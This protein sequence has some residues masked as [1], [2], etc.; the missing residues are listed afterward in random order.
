[1]QTTRRNRRGFTLVEFLVVAGIALTAFSMAPSTIQKAREAARRAT[2][3]NN[4]KQLGIALHNYH[5]TYK[6][7][8]PGWNARVIT[9]GNGARSGWQTS[10]LP[11]VDQAPIFEAVFS[12]LANT[13]DSHLPAP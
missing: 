9:P 3:K 2:C 11:F 12:G 5:E 6:A 8:P 7:F 1:M 4:L 13:P 10:I